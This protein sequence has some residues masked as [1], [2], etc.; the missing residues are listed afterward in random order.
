MNSD[1]FWRAWHNTDHSEKENN[2]HS[3]STWARHPLTITLE[4]P[5]IYLVTYPT[6]PSTRCA[7]SN[8]TG[9][10]MVK[11]NSFAIL[12]TQTRRLLSCASVALLRNVVLWQTTQRVIGVG[13]GCKIYL[14]RSF[15]VLMSFNSANFTIPDTSAPFTLTPPHPSDNFTSALNYI[16]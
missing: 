10:S 16:T 8:F 12:P 5:T 15:I 2:F 3:R 7:V 4:H 6:Y 1:H 14:Q 13:C 9:F 11:L